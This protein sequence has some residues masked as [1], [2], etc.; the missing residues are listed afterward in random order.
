MSTIKIFTLGHCAKNFKHPLANITNILAF[1]LI[2]ENSQK[3]ARLW[4]LSSVTSDHI[5][6]LT[7]PLFFRTNFLLKMELIDIEVDFFSH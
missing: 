7:P 3:L 1:Q 2:R 6:D 4:I 5:P